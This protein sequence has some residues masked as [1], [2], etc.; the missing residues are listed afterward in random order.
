MTQIF[1]G[2]HSTAALIHTNRMT[3]IYEVTKY[4][5]TEHENLSQIQVRVQ[6]LVTST[7]LRNQRIRKHILSIV[8]QLA[9]V[10]K[11]F[12]NCGY[13]VTGWTIFNSVGTGLKKE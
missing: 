8:I 6:K 3:R 13:P 9:T 4:T 5:I 2:F 11:S 10:V 7:R 12:R 1:D